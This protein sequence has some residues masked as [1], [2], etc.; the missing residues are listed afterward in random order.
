MCIVHLYIVSI[1]VFTFSYNTICERWLI[2]FI[3]F[4]D[5]VIISEEFDLFASSVARSDRHMVDE[6]R[7]CIKDNDIRRSV[8]NHEPATCHRDAIHSAFFGSNLFGRQRAVRWNE[9]HRP[10]LA[11]NWGKFKNPIMFWMATSIYKYGKELTLPLD[12][13]VA[14]RTSKRPIHCPD[15]R[16]S[17]ECGTM[18]FSF[19]QKKNNLLICIWV[20][21]CRMQWGL[22][23]AS[24]TIKILNWKIRRHTAGYPELLIQLRAGTLLMDATWVA[25]AKTEKREAQSS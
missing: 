15:A 25:L 1:R 22:W 16:H 14:S 2:N 13:G 18:A 23:I 5:N 7:K 11:T 17:S 4:T 12:R 19:A 9:S 21:L 8:A 6:H 24:K 10:P 3:I 20:T